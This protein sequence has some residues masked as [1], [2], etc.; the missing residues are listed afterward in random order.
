MFKRPDLNPRELVPED[1][2][3]GA[4]AN[5]N[6]HAGRFSVYR[7]TGYEPREGGRPKEVRE[8]LGS[9]G[10]DGKSGEWKFKYGRS[11]LAARNAEALERKARELSRKLRE[12]RK[13][14]LTESGARALDEVEKR[15]AQ[16]TDDRDASRITYR[17]D[18]MLMISLLSA[19]AGKSSAMS[20]ASYWR[21]FIGELREIIPGLP[22]AS[23]SH[24]TIR[25]MFQMLRP[26]EFENFLQEQAAPLFEKARRSLHMDGQAVRASKTETSASGRYALNVYDGESG[27]CAATLLVGD[28][29]NEITCGREIL[30]K[31]DLGPGDLVTA[32]ALSTHPPLVEYIHS[33]GADYCLAVK[34]NAGFELEDE[35]DCAFKNNPTEIF[36]DRSVERA[37][38]RIDTRESR[39]LPGST[40]PKDA[41]SR[42]P[43]LRQGCVIETTTTREFKNGRKDKTVLV[44]RFICSVPLKAAYKGSLKRLEEDRRSEAH[45]LV[46]RAVRGHWGVEDRL[47]YVLDMSWGQDRIHAHDEGYLENRLIINKQAFNILTEARRTVNERSNH[48]HSYNTLQELCS[49]PDGAIEYLG[50]AYDQGMFKQAARDALSR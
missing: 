3:K 48:R 43:G 49:T 31:L 26:S 20:I 40:L 9:I 15:S 39:L 17:L 19:L 7:I 47:H 11:Y 16:L 10:P 12:A 30:S 36:H 27:L 42:W 21:K 25:R 28:K 35:I 8:P 5:W 13:P 38:D 14:H 23:P 46:E 41:A 29:T 32:D 37:G 18:H 50:I 22:D 1:L 44:R 33:T 2:R 24:D 6:G 45:D 4:I 34:S